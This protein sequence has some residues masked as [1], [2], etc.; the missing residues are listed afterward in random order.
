MDG[1]VKRT[2]AVN[3]TKVL[4]DSRHGTEGVTASSTTLL[5]PPD[6]V[7]VDPTVNAP[8]SEMDKMDISPPPL[9]KREKNIWIVVRAFT[10]AY[11][12]TLPFPLAPHVLAW[13]LEGRVVI[14]PPGLCYSARMESKRFTDGL[15]STWALELFRFFFIIFHIMARGYTGSLSSSSSSTLHYLSSSRLYPLFGI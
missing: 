7:A 12:Y 15:Q 6:N 11:V 5:S 2:C 14:E 1:N 4:T 3:G 10:P 9:Q 13:S 8:Q